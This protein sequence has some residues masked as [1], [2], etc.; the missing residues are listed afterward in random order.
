MA[1]EASDKEK[2]SRGALYRYWISGLRLISHVLLK[3]FVPT[4]KRA[5]YL[6]RH[7]LQEQHAEDLCN[8]GAE[9]E[10]DGEAT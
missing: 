8:R 4:G 9:G 6:Q 1:R 7:G 2:V 3:V 10:V 5:S